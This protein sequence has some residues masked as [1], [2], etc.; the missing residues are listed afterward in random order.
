M[1]FVHYEKPDVATRVHAAERALLPRSVS[2]VL[3]DL[4]EHAIAAYD[5]DKLV[6]MFCYSV[7]ATG[8]FPARMMAEG[9]VVANAYR[10]QGLGTELWVKAI[11]RHRIRVIEVYIV[12]AKAIP[13]LRAVEA[14]VP[15]VKII[16]R[17][18]ES[19]RRRKHWKGAVTSKHA[20]AWQK[21]HGPSQEAL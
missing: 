5:E 7:P 1:K 18:G 19:L 13:M 2:E 15:H 16:A 10:G 9:T 3:S 8:P 21:D 12:N 4:A 17:F 20:K 14:R 11:R 6:A